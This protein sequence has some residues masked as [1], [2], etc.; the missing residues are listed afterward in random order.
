MNPKTSGPK[1]AAERPRGRPPGLKSGALQEK[2]LDA[3]ERLFAEYGFD[4]VPV[5]RVAEEAGVNPALVHYYFGSKRKLLY[6]VIER[7][8]T[9]LAAG[10]SAMQE[11]GPE[12]ITDVTALLFGTAAAH[13]ALPRLV[14][15]EVLLSGGRTRDVFARDYAPRLGG[16]LPGLIRKAQK[17]GRIGRGLD[18]GVITLVV[19][20]LC[21]F[22]FIAR[23]L[24]EPV[25]GIE[26]NEAGLDRY[27]EQVN[28][29]LTG[30]ITA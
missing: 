4:A 7:A 10:L 20:G 15:R 14:T 5:R 17:A 26:Y 23:S 28:R 30:E 18:P 11:S 19:L 27:L 1:E 16:A 13:P 22:P 6:A 29:L 25:L 2:L 8:I 21:L 3:A 9:H 24:A 12:R